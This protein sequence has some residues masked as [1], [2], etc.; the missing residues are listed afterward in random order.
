VIELDVRFWPNSDI[1]GRPLSTGQEPRFL[2]IVRELK[3]PD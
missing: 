1:R 2:A 3:F